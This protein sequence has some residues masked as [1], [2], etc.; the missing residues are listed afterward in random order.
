LI[1][2]GALVLQLAVGARPPDR[3]TGQQPPLAVWPRVEDR[4]RAVLRVGAVLADPALE[5]ATRSGLP[6][7]I[8]ARVELWRD[9]LI[10]NLEASESWSAVLL[11]EPLERQYMVRPQSGAAKRFN[12]Y[13][14][15]RAA[16]ESE[17]GLGVAPRRSGRFYYT[18]VLEIETLSL[19]DLDELE[20]W[21]Q[22][23]LGPAVSGRRS[24][25]DAVGEGAKRLLIR[26]LGLPTRR[27][28]ARSE[29]FR[30]E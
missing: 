1:L 21:L 23:E 17:H 18:A 19:S 10:D 6:I 12:S 22:G 16:V 15:A 28:E 9:G 7:R 27:V 20:R 11:F 4:A 5:E 2:A 8:R 25:G 13:A 14:E 26:V 24:L 30:I 3:P 29:R